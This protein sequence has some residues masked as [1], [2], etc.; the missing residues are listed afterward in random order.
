[1]AVFASDSNTYRGEYITRGGEG[2][3]EDGGSGTTF[4]KAPNSIGAVE[5]SLYIDNQGSKPKTVSI[6]DKSK[7]SSRTYIVTSLADTSDNM[8]FDHVY[9]SGVGHLA[10]LNTTPTDTEI[11]IKTLHGDN[12]GMIHSSVDQRIIIEDSDSPFPAAIRVYDKS[13]MTLP[14]GK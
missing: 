14:D 3:V 10:L 7:D 12:T 5:S 9:I 4:I 1:M 2:Y 6:A 8:T 13:A 11:T